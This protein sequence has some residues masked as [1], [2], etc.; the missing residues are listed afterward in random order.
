MSPPG[1]SQLQCAHLLRGY[2]SCDLWSACAAPTS[3]I[4]SA[5]SYGWEIRISQPASFA[6]FCLLWFLEGGRAH[7]A[8]GPTPRAYR[9]RPPW[10]PPG[11]PVPHQCSGGFLLAPGR[12]SPSPAPPVA[13]RDTSVTVRSW[14]ALPSA[15]VMS[16]IDFF[17]IA[18]LFGV[19]GGR[20]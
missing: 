5:W 15:A 6:L 2:P 3:Q 17:V 16:S 13:S 20:Q 12:F 9:P 8:P 10:P 1:D 7:K 14:V 19:P 4:Y 11:P 18:C